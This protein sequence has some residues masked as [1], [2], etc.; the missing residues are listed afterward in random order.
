MLP[1]V[2]KESRP[3]Q[4]LLLHLGG[5][6]L[7]VES[8]D[9]DI[10]ILQHHE[11]DEG[12]VEVEAIVGALLQPPESKRCSSKPAEP[13]RSLFEP[14]FIAA[15]KDDTNLLAWKSWSTTSGSTSPLST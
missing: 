8:L 15:V 9:D 4:V 5:K 11:G 14:S 6:L 7:H 1:V 3:P 13:A 10:E 12:L 2:H